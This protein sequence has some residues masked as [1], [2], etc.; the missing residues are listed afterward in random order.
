MKRNQHT[1]QNPTTQYRQ[2]GYEPQKQ[3]EPGLAQDSYPKPD[4]GENTYEGSNKLMDKVAVITGADSGIGRAVAIAFAREGADVVL[5][6]LPNEE[7]DAQEVITLIEKAG[8]TALAIPGDISSETQ[9]KEIIELAVEGFGGVDILINNAGK[10]LAVKSLEDLSTEQLVK[11]Y[12]VNVFAMFWLSK[13]ALPHLKTGASII[14][15]TSIQATTPSSH[16]LDYA[17]TKAAMANF[18]KG[19]AQQLAEK[20]IRVN[21]VAPGPI[22]TPLQPSGGQF[23]E[24]LKD[25]GKETPLGRTTC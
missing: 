19:L 15:T 13:Y 23:P 18:T 24:D 22:W 20:G 8:R 9:C 21:G 25:F 2:E 7:E 5:S 17:S 11:T 10:Q 4:H 3:S 16:L 1:P 12:E 6:Y 14:N